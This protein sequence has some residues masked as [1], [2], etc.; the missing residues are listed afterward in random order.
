MHCLACFWLPPQ[1]VRSKLHDVFP[2]AQLALTV[3]F[4]SNAV[5]YSPGRPPAVPLAVRSPYTSAWSSTRENGTLNT[6]G[7]M[8]WTGQA[9]GWEGIVTVDAI[10]Y[11]WMGT[12]LAGLPAL[13]NF[14][15]ATPLSVSYDSQYSNFTFEAGPVILTAR[16][17]SPVTPSDLC[18]TSV[19]LSYL[20]VSYQSSD[21]ATHDVKL[22]A[23]VDSAW[24]NFGA[25]NTVTYTMLV[26]STEYEPNTT[27][28]ETSMF[29]W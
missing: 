9:L 19:P 8:F 5:V 1:S 26:D 27:V 15:S 10:S 2:A 12:N 24:N 20:E 17:F 21:N 7:V 14:K 22:Y 25:A 28:T 11:E 6:N 4:R 16:F 29:T 3:P 18:R 13:D 23:D